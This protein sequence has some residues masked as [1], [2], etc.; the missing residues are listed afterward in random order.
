MKNPKRDN[1]FKLLELKNNLS[2]VLQSLQ[3]EVGEKGQDMVY[4]IAKSEGLRICRKAIDSGHITADGLGFQ[5]CLEVYA[6]SGLG[7]LKVKQMAWDMGWAVIECHDSFE[8]ATIFK[9]EGLSSGPVC[10][11]TRG[12]LAAFME[13]TR[14]TAGQPVSSLT[15]IE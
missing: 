8:A 9:R 15:C 2:S 11:Y 5:K 14:R 13:E 3:K 10:H 12:V 4:R 6:G 1:K 7:N